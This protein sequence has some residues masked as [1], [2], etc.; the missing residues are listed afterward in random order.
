MRGINTYLNNEHFAPRIIALLLCL[1]GLGVLV[2][3]HSPLLLAGIYPYSTLMGYNTAIG[4]CACGLGL[5][6][7]MT[8]RWSLTLISSSILFI[9]GVLTLLELLAGTS[10]NTANWF[11]YFLNEPPVRSQPSPPIASAAFL[12]AGCAIL[13]GFNPQGSKTVIACLCCIIIFFLTLIA[14]LGQGLGILPAFMWR[15]IKMA[16]HTALGLTLFA[17]GLAALR[18]NAAITAF[19]RFNVFSRLVTGFVFMSLLFIGIGSIGS[20]QINNVVSITQE[21]YEDPV[22]VNNAVLRIKNDINKLNRQMKDI[23]VNPQLASSLNIHENL[24]KTEFAVIQELNIL[25]RK[26]KSPDITKLRNTF[27]RWET[28]IYSNYEVLNAGDIE[29]YRQRTLNEIQELTITLEYLCENITQQAQDRIL[30]LN[31]EVI[32][33]KNHAANLMLIAISFFLLVGVLVSAAITRSLNSQLQRIRDTM[34]KLAEGDTRIEIPFL[35]HPHEMGIMAKTIAVFAENMEA[36]KQNALLLVKHQAD[37][38]SSN[39]RLAQTNKELETFAYVASHDLKSPLRGI[40]Q[41]STWIE[42]DLAEK[43]Y[44]DVDKHTVML[45]NRIQRMEKLLDDMLI[46][47]RAGKVDGKTI[48]VDVAH[49]ASELFEIQ[50]T[51]PGIRLELGDHLPK[52]ETLGT[53]FE[54][55]LRNL[56]SNALKHHDLDQGVI[57]LDSQDINNHFY[58]FSVSDDGPGIP[59]K[60][61]ERVFGMFQTLKPRDELEGS[62][63]GLAL[64]KKLVENY[65]GTITVFS[66][67]RGCRF[68]FT[69]PKVIERSNS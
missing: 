51:K 68:S 2:S 61:Q 21:L 62:G 29:S 37:L 40:A 53:P 49:M 30:E 13:L 15:G 17:I 5:Y 32:K 11:F 54:Q 57:R 1:L 41:L 3:W 20:L 43:Q 23:A 66:E 7:V 63:M 36:R 50:N 6:A 58:E 64:I 56:F 4:F 22:Q 48:T 31:D 26:T 35:D 9:I 67:G 52:F 39:H 10:F 24:A 42:E 8:Q 69:W 55:I 46:F 12:F 47:Y 25:E 60:F 33:T 59:E 16:P 65:G 38:E 19:N 18:L 14:I 44:A 45:R 27:K 34:E 28:A